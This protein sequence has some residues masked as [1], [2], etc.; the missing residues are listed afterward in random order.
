VP[1]DRAVKQIGTLSGNPVAAAAGLATLDVLREPGA[2]ER[3]FA[4]GRALMDGFTE[5]LAKHGVA[6]QVMGEAPM[7]DIVFKAGEIADYRGTMGADAGL[8]K[9]LNA[10]L[11]KRGVFKG[12]NK[13]YVSLAHTDEDVAKTLDAFDDALAG[14]AAN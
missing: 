8:N 13:F 1:A 5:R 12:D 6:G 10:E 14:I 11:L 7:F 3:L 9:R 4:T 2:Y